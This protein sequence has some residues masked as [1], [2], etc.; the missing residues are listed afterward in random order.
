MRKVDQV[1]Y[2]IG[3]VG[4]ERLIIAKVGVQNIKNFLEAVAKGEAVK[5]LFT[6]GTFDAGLEATNFLALC[7]VDPDRINNVFTPPGV[8]ERI[9]A[10]LRQTGLNP[11]F[12]LF[13]LFVQFLDAHSEFHMP[14]L[15]VL[16]SV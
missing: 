3:L 16:C 12:L 7:R 5:N 4:H 1:T 2:E 9:S 13:A 15:N 14:V 10:P 11:S 8:L 6:I